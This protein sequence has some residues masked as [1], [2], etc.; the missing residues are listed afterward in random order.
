MDKLPNVELKPPSPNV[1]V[2]ITNGKTAPVFGHRDIHAWVKNNSAV[3]TPMLHLEFYI[4]GHGTTYY[5]IALG[6]N[7]MRK[8][9]HHCSWSTSGSKTIRAKLS[10]QGGAQLAEVEGAIMIYIGDK[11]YQANYLVKCADGSY[12]NEADIQ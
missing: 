6:P 10:L 1:T 12:K 4:E 5:S 2:C 7:E 11:E 8:N 3:A 9:T